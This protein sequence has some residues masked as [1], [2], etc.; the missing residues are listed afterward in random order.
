MC[1][2]WIFSAMYD[3][4]VLMGV[5]FFILSEYVP[6]NAFPGRTKG[7]SGSFLPNSVYT[8]SSTHCTALVLEFPH[9]DTVTM[10]TIDLDRRVS[11][12]QRC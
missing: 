9:C 8:N 1:I 4:F 6:V 7:T 2:F 3:L 11:K 10:T 12:L 5:H